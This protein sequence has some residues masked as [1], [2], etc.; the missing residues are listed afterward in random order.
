MDALTIK[1][2]N[3]ISRRKNRIYYADY[4]RDFKNLKGTVAVE[5]IEISES[6]IENLRRLASGEA[7]CFELVEELKKKYMQRI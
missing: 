2:T 7:T 6:A 4:E 3:N 5:G 1:K